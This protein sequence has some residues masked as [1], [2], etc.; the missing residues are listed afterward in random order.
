MVIFA[1]QF[2]TLTLAACKC[3]VKQKKAWL[4]LS[5]LTIKSSLYQR[6]CLMCHMLCLYVS[7]RHT[8]AR[9]APGDFPNI[10]LLQRVYSEG[11]EMDFV[12]EE[13]GGGAK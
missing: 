5:I 11:L 8:A 10:D 12:V 2:C 3:Q 1:T 9:A 7:V 13:V 4:G 6:H